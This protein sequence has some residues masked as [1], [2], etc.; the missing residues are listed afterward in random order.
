M[1]KGV[2]IQAPSEGAFENPQWGET[3]R[4][5]FVEIQT[6]LLKEKH[7]IDILLSLIKEDE[8]SIN[9][10]YLLSLP[11]LPPFIYDYY[12]LPKLWKAFQSLGNILIA[13]VE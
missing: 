11:S 7:K 5:V 6:A 4:Y 1:R 12:R 3:F 9:K 10:R 13:H 8:M 2:Q